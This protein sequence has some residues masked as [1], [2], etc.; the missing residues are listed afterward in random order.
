MGL[1]ASE[2]L[3]AAQPCTT[4]KH[5][6]SGI[7]FDGGEAWIVFHPQGKNGIHASM[8][9]ETSENA[10]LRIDLGG[11]NSNSKV[12]IRGGEGSID[13]DT[14]AKGLTAAFKQVQKESSN[15][16]LG[17]GPPLP[18]FGLQRSTGIL[19]TKV[20]RKT[21]HKKLLVNHDLLDRILKGM[22]AMS[23]SAN[24]P[25]NLKDTAPRQPHRYLRRIGG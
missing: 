12:V 19:T 13:F 2:R 21:D 10:Q 9:L 6:G 18:T 16:N 14:V 17:V 7:K 11:D 22:R 1:A 4:K 8:L 25:K 15:Q 23:E 24:L 20:G 3:S 5:A